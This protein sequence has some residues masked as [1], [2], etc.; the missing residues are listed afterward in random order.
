[1]MKKFT[2]LVAIV[3]LVIAGIFIFFFFRM[4][5]NDAKT[6]AD[7]PVAYGNYDQTITDLYGAI[8]AN[9]PD[10]ATTI[11]NMEYKADQALNDLK[12]QASVRI[13]SLT[14][15]DGDLMKVSLEIAVLGG[16]E[17]ETL[18]AYRISKG[19][20]ANDE[21]QLAK[22]FADLRDQRQAAYSNYLELAESNK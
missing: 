13:S 11:D 19:N 8:L 15:N 14:R 21:D 16:N 18:K 6:L 1:M 2:G 3:L 17:L 9:N 4:G 12:I 7:F 10:N 22:D 20:R 5:S